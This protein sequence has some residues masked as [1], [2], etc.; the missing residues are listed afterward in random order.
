MKR[1]AGVAFTADGRFLCVTDGS[2]HQVYSY[3][4]QPDGSLIDKQRYYYLHVDT[5][6]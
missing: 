3:L 5:V 1:A 2:I 4:I 6:D